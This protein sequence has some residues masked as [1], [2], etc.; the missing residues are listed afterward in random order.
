MQVI[1]WAITLFTLCEVPNKKYTKFPWILRTWWACSFLLSLSRTAI[2]ARFIIISHDRVKV[3]K[4]VELLG[5]LTSTSLLSI[6][7]R[8]KTGIVFYVVNGITD[9]LLNGKAE[10]G[11]E[12][13]RN[14]LYEKATFFNLI[15]FSWLNPLFAV[16]IKKPL[17]QNEVPNV[18]I[19]DSAGFLSHSFDES[20]KHVQEKSSN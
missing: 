19:R 17:D 12:S 5:L 13:K 1:I 10:K 8:G 14:C 15:S 18:D 6:S 11:S 20:L 2:D 9:P 3:H 4:F 7:I 16:G